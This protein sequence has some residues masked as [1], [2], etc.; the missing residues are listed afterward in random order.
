MILISSL[1]GQAQ[2]AEAAYA[3][4]VSG[5]TLLNELQN[6]DNDMRFS[7]TQATAFVSQWRVAS[8]IP[9]TASGFSATL[10]EQV[11]AAGIGTGNFNL[12]IR[13]TNRLIELFE[14]DALDIF[15]DGVA[16]D[17]LVDL[18]NYWQC[19]VTPDN[20][21]YAAARL[22]TLQS[23]TDALANGEISIEA[24][25]SRADIVIDEPT[26]SVRT[27][28]F[29][30]SSTLTEQGLRQG[31]GTFQ[32]RPLST[33]TTSGHSLGGHLAM[34]F[35]R[36][37]SGLGANA[38][39]VN[40][41][42][43]RSSN[44]NVAH[45][46]M[47][48]GGDSSFDA[49]TI[50]NVFG[51]EG[52]E[53]AA[54]NTFLLNQVGGYHGTFIENAGPSASFGHSNEQMTDSLAL[55]D[56]FAKIDPAL[57]TVDL[58]V[59][60]D[61]ITDVL[62]AAS[63][64]PA[65]SLEASLD[66]VRRL[67]GNSG[68]QNVAS[69][70]TDKRESFYQNFYNPDFQ[71]RI[72][73]F[74]G[75]L[76]IESLNGKDALWI[77]ANAFGDIGYRYALTELN[78]FAIIGEEA[79]YTEHNL[80]GELDLYKPTTGIGLT[81]EYLADRSEMLRWKNFDY[82]ADG[83][84]ALRGTQ[85]ETIQYI[86]KTLK[87]TSGSDLTFNIAGRRRGSLSNPAK[88]VFG[89]E[90]NDPIAGSDLAVGD[91][92]YGG[93]GDDTLDG[94]GGNDYLEGGTGADNLAGG[95]GDDEL[96]GAAGNDTLAGGAGRD[97]LDGGV[98]FD[99]YDYFS[100]GGPDTIVDA[101]GS[102]QVF[103]DNILLTGGLSVG[104]NLWWSEDERFQF[105][106]YAEDD[107]TQ[108]LSVGG[109]GTF[110]IK[111]FTPGALGIT[112]EEAPPP[113][114][115]PPGGGR[116]I[117]GIYAPQI[118][119]SPSDLTNP[120][121]DY[122]YIAIV[123]T[124]YPHDYLLEDDLGNLVRDPSR[125]WTGGFQS[126][127]GSDG[128]DHIVGSDFGNGLAGNAGSDHLTGGLSPDGAGG[129]EGNDFI[130]GG[131][132]ANVPLEDWVNV[133]A[134]FPEGEIR[135]ASD[136]RLFGGTGDDV[137]FGGTAGDLES[138]LDPTT[139]SADHK[140]DWISGDLGDDDLYGSIGH[141]VLLGGGGKDSVIGGPGDDVL[142]GDDSFS[143]SHTTNPA[144]GAW[145]W[146]ID[147]GSSSANL[148]FFPIS[149]MPWLDWSE[150]Y[151]KL[152]GDDDVLFGG[153]GND[154]LVG[155]SGNDILLG[156]IGND[157]LSGWE[158]DDTL[159]GGDGDDVIAG[160]FGRYEQA[161]DRLVG[162]THSVPAGFL[163]INTGDSGEPE[164]RG[165]DYLDGGGG[166]DVLY[167]EGGADIVFGGSGN[168]SLWGD[169]G[170]LTEAFHG[171][172][173][174][175]GGS[176]ADTV[177]GGFGDDILIGGVGDDVLAGGDGSDTYIFAQGDGADLIQ[178]SGWQGID[179]LVLSDY[180][181]SEVSITRELA[182]GL[183][184]TGTSGDV[185]TIES[186]A[187][188]ESAGI[189]HIQFADGTMLD[190]DGIRGLLLAL[191]SIPDQDWSVASGADDVIDTFGMPG[192]SA[193]GFVLLD[194]GAGN[195]LV[196]GDSNA[197]VNGNEGDDQL[198][199]GRTLIGGEGNDYIADG[200]SLLGGPGDDDLYNGVLL[201]GG[202][203]NDFLDGGFGAS[204]YL[205]S[206]EDSGH[207][208]VH[209]SAGLDQF[210]LA[211]WYY[212]SIGI[213][214]WQD[215]L[216]D[217]QT[218]DTISINRGIA[219]GLLPE[220][221]LIAPQDYAALETLYAAGV[222]DIDALEF[223]PG[224]TL[225]D[226][227]LS[228][229]TVRLVSPVEGDLGP[230]VVLNAAI[231]PGNVVSIV[232]PRSTD[233]LGAG[234]E[235][236]RF[237]DGTAATM[238][239]LFA[240]SPPAPDFDPAFVPNG[241]PVF[242]FEAGDGVQFIDDPGVTTIEFGAGI[243][244]DMLTLGVGSLLIRVGDQ[245]D[246]I[247]ILNFDPSDVI[248]SQIE[249]IAFA[250]GTQLSY[251][252]LIARGFD[253]FG[254]EDDDFLTG[255][256][257]SDRFYGLAGNDFYYFESRPGFDIVEDESGE[258]DTV[259]VGSAIAPGSVTV[260]F[261]GDYLALELSPADR[262]AIRWQPGAGY[263]V[264][265]VAFDDGTVWDAAMLESLAVTAENAVPV[266]G[267]AIVDQTALE[268]TTFSF[269][270]P[271]DT[272]VDANDGE[273]LNFD[274][275]RANGSPL[276]TWMTFDPAAQ[277][278]SGT[279]SNDDVGAFD[280]TVTA[281]DSG[282]LSASDTFTLT[283]ENTNDPPVLL[284][285]LSNQVG[286]Q[287]APLSFSIPDGSFDD[288][289]ARDVLTFAVALA[290]GHT[291][292][293][294]LDFDATTQTF[295]GTPSEGDAG[296]YLISVAATDSAGAS[297]VG[298]FALSISDAATTV[299]SYQGTKRND[300]I[301]TDFRNDFIDAG[302]GDDSIESGAGR[303]LVIAGKGDDRVHAGYG[304]DYLLGGKG[305]DYLFGEVGNDVLFGE[306]DDD[307][308]DGGNGNN[309]LDGGKGKD[310]I[311]AG[312]GNNLIIGGPGSDHLYG[313][314]EHDVFLFNRGDGKATLH[315]EGAA[316]AGNTDTISLG[317][318]IAP[319]DIVLRRK[320]NDLIVSTVGSDEDD[321]DD[322]AIK[323]VLDGWYE[324][325][326]DQ[327]TITRLQLIDDSVQIYDFAELAARFDAATVGR[328]RQWR[329]GAAMGET[330][331]STSNMEAIGGA[332]AYQYAMQRTL[333]G[334]PTTTIQ[335]TLADPLFGESAQLVV[336]HDGSTLAAFLTSGDGEDGGAEDFF[337]LFN[338]SGAIDGPMPPLPGE[339]DEV[340]SLS[341]S[342]RKE[343]TNGD[344]SNDDE[345]LESLIE[346]WFGGDHS[347]SRSLTKFLDEEHA[348]GREQRKT[349]RGAHHLTQDE[350][351]ACW[352]RTQRLLEAHL[353]NQD[354]AALAGGEDHGFSPGLGGGGYSQTVLSGD[355]LPRV[356]GHHLRRLEGL[357]EGLTKL[358]T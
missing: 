227:A 309:V 219:L 236:V 184:I 319:D 183:T 42:G 213:P 323:I 94:H 210:S 212:P 229:E 62:R 230:Y 214:D 125:P 244:A 277:H 68:G 325:T 160:D 38:L 356:A 140:G 190:H 48:L 44:S 126:L 133:S 316:T 208:T 280:V 200:V 276:P 320:N 55:Y 45:L 239:E 343:R 90:E 337:A 123:S 129:G 69:T 46:F 241:G 234:I 265:E 196:F 303:D 103:Y 294:W 76:S 122:Q 118:F 66:S 347:G 189:E 145:M 237:P 310:H 220:L 75:L 267:N 271:G 298:G 304:N 177:E 18:Y 264:E 202:S 313:G 14:T 59:G 281:T 162:L 194:A 274:A 342:A 113:T 28:Q 175:D 71:N 322:A 302:K 60:I 23:E 80:N 279:P 317:K 329:A 269:T 72:S 119:D 4:L 221:P 127:W 224:I 197:V 315:V 186:L 242:L 41:L 74:S 282:G 102:G 188:N 206:V 272:F 34:A 43:F 82:A 40:G 288:I 235:E 120:P 157:V 130:E 195:D 255:T 88:V 99:T 296:L 35:T 10:F 73:S 299:A 79:L 251:A 211:E 163:D 49:G 50:R 283:V 25:R 297:V 135:G 262:I 83:Q 185:I 22:V 98:G 289:D 167:G 170:Y 33:L 217:P 321:D 250:D 143:T 324:A 305:R 63:N 85:L 311:V 358:Y 307:H 233:L 285:P 336:D 81:K 6:T 199:G 57:N 151:Y 326:S 84:R 232:I 137:I 192:N 293:V 1:F 117:L 136:D 187:G 354:P 218:E 203:G 142:V 15:A 101:D 246:A 144:D 178:D 108:T 308:L 153:A 52:P 216:F 11:D 47:M 53:F 284:S 2:L 327:R 96:L 109:S 107:G 91:H 252:E 261:M 116:D 87:N 156:E 256:N 155:Q 335:E 301:R 150:S 355:R 89:S 331:L 245:G 338:D 275:S 318:G 165:S 357:D 353:A 8:H 179:V 149:V 253:F 159:L 70:E 292:P 257:A 148:Q 290:D 138:L 104:P 249:N 100:G 36:L 24:L 291:L 158:G 340:W 173:Y 333:A 238:S 263:Q 110:F 344:G 121:P 286:N 258:F 106:L 228:W 54:Q 240:L 295:S 95:D 243:T 111:N 191:D 51:L 65:L 154:I 93:G 105:A 207:D 350:V 345:L 181:Q 13:G 172:D 341:L 147:G 270:I 97:V 278:F 26:K 3:D 128:G 201:I 268:D 231:T 16:L 193:G 182:G 64:K 259:F 58:E 287:S 352:R 152:A 139:P 132:F 180:L 61:E 312:A 12:A 20:I 9:D 314:S 332:L 31:L 37:F 254:T 29:V 92:L 141:D 32:T 204:R 330:L 248:I 171:A 166:D 223:G 328:N 164:Q 78:S 19:L 215:R 247:H 86:D 5:T 27:I 7:P 56:L 114:A 67:F 334:V 349:S 222:I 339:M 300:V 39:A 168:D 30:N 176:G 161:N 346:K 266:V 174:L 112:L 273:P 209:D 77:E 351:A 169:A 348:W 134:P 260:A 146:R 131:D 198:F 124:A 205:V 225:G 226:L 17:Q 21:T 115:T 306:G